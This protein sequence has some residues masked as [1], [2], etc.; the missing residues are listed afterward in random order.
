MNQHAHSKH[1]TEAE[2]HRLRK[3]DQLATQ[4]EKQVADLQLELKRQKDTVDRVLRR[5]PA[6]NLAPLRH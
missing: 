2:T 3:R 5:R 1:R 4:L 6:H